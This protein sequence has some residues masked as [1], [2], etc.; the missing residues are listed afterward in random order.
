M[1]INVDHIWMQFYY[2]MN[3]YIV[4]WYRDVIVIT[5]FPR[6]HYNI[7]P[8]FSWSNKDRNIILFF[9]AF[10]CYNVYDPLLSLATSPYTNNLIIQ[11]SLA[12][13]TQTQNSDNCLFNP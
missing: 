9:Y 8:D 11:T 2:Q 6:K 4:R 12:I 7:K 3:N 1:K 5:K 13:R 10:C